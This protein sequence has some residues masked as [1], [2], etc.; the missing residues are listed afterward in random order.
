M[1]LVPRAAVEPNPADQALVKSNVGRPVA[2]RILPGDPVET[3]RFCVRVVGRNAG[4]T[5]IA[6]RMTKFFKS[7]SRISNSTYREQTLSVPVLF[8]GSP[9]LARQRSHLPAE[10]D[11]ELLRSA[12]VTS[13]PSTAAACSAT[14][15]R[16]MMSV[17]GS[18]SEAFPFYWPTKHRNLR[19]VAAVRNGTRASP[20]R[21]LAGRSA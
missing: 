4:L 10:H 6:S 17:C 11:A 21:G 16:V 19:P 13:L 18:P 5:E 2:D 12:P 1:L 15:S 9:I 14:P 7:L 3:G 8:C 20:I